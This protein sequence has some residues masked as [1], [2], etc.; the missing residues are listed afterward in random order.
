MMD[1]SDI[2][3]ILHIGSRSSLKNEHEPD[4]SDKDCKSAM[5]RNNARLVRMIWVAAYVHCCMREF[6]VS[7]DQWVIQLM[8]NQFREEIRLPMACKDY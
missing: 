2:L 1:W 5:S 7:Y 3:R 6:D 8:C 4:A